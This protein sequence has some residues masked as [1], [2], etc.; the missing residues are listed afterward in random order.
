MHFTL[1]SGAEIPKMVNNTT[2]FL[3][4]KLISKSNISLHHSSVNSIQDQEKEIK[5]NCDSS[6]R[7]GAFKTDTI[8]KN[9]T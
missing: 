2:A 7:Q 4:K 1:I 6:K 3:F 5:C 9:I 8:D